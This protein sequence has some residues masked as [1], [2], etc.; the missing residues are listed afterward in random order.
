MYATAMRL[1]ESG[2]GFIIFSVFVGR[3]KPS[4]ESSI[5]LKTI[6][7]IQKKPKVEKLFFHRDFEGA[8]AWVMSFVDFAFSEIITPQT[9]KKCLRE[10]ADMPSHEYGDSNNIKYRLHIGMLPDDMDEIDWY[11]GMDIERKKYYEIRTLIEMLIPAVRL[12][13]DLIK[14]NPQAGLT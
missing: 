2:T 5:L 7:E 3:H 1:K 9:F 10:I 13:I 8:G 12:S 11:K 14:E 4:E 6:D